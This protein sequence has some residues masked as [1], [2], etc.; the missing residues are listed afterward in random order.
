MKIA[1][2]RHRGCVSESKSS[3]K[4]S[5]SSDE[6]LSTDAGYLHHSNHTCM[7]EPP[8]TP[9]TLRKVDISRFDGKM[10]GTADSRRPDET[11]P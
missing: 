9:S 3:D 4:I 8:A 11:P 7:N 1:T 2:A 10:V 5:S 6:S